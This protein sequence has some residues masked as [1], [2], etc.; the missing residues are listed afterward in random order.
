MEDIKWK[1]ISKVR[2][3]DDV[4]W[5]LVLENWMKLN[6]Q[7]SIIS[8]GNDCAYIHNEWSNCSV[9]NCALFNSG[10]PA[11]M[12]S[13]ICKNS[14][15]GRSDICFRAENHNAWRYIEAKF[16]KK[17]INSFNEND[18]DKGFFDS[19]DDVRRVDSNQLY[20]LSFSI[21]TSKEEL[22]PDDLNSQIK[23][24]KEYARLYADFASLVSPEISRKN[25]LPQFGLYPVGVLVA[26]SKVGQRK[27]P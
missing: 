5:K 4:N 6:I 20:N 27:K 18:F 11:I 21:F 15:N 23:K 14:Q 9:F 19:Y 24:I 26:G 12:E 17:D 3:P 13:Q 8:R 16:R 25:K 1:Y 7:Y 22:I 10:Y 2:K